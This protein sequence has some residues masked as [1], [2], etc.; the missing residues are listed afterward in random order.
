MSHGIKTFIEARCKVLKIWEFCWEGFFSEKL[1]KLV[2]Y[3]V[4][5]TLLWI[6]REGKTKS[7]LITRT[8]LV[9]LY[10]DSKFDVPKG[11]YAWKNNSLKC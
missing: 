7:I 11:N 4:G 10:V 1:E 6:S 8:R 5:M 3:L 9:F 2:V